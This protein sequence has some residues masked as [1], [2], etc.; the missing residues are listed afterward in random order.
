MVKFFLRVIR[1]D[2]L[3]EYI[4]YTERF[5][6]TLIILSARIKDSGYSKVFKIGSIV[7]ALREDGGIRGLQ[8]E[9]RSKNLV[10][11]LLRSFS[12]WK[13]THSLFWESM[14]QGEDP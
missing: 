10:I 8:T 1:K 14:K 4:I 2:L 11:E 5:K 9:S 13:K 3:T 12:R 7:A 6:L